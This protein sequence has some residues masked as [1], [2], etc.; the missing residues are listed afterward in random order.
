MTKPMS[1][2]LLLACIAALE[3]LLQIYKDDADQERLTRM[4]VL[5]LKASGCG[6][7]GSSQG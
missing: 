7:A 4:I 2:A 1:Y 6:R 3:Y 5:T